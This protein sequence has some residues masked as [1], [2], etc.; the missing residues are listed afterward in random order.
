MTL[1]NQKEN[2]ELEELANRLEADTPA[3]NTETPHP[4][5][6]S[7]KDKAP[8]LC[9]V[10]NKYDKIDNNQQVKVATKT[11]NIPDELKNGFFVI[12]QLEDGKK[13]V[14][15][16]P[17][18]N[19][20][21]S[22]KRLTG[23]KDNMEQWGTFDQVVNAFN[24]G[25]PTY[26]NRGYDGIGF[27]FTK[28]DTYWGID[29]DNCI[30]PKGQMDAWAKDIIDRVDS[31]YE[32]SPSGKGVKIWVKADFAKWIDRIQVKFRLINGEKF[33]LEIDDKKNIITPEDD[34]KGID[35]YFYDYYF[36][37]TGNGDKNKIINKSSID[38]AKYYKRLENTL[39]LKKKNY[40]YDR[41]SVGTNSNKVDIEAYLSHYNVLIKSK[42]RKDSR[43]YYYLTNGCLFNPK[44]DKKDAAIIQDVDGKLGYKCFHTSCADNGW[45]EAKQKI[46]GSDSIAPFMKDERGE[47]WKHSPEYSKEIYAGEIEDLPDN[48]QLEDKENIVFP[49]DCYYGLAKEFAEY[50][51]KY[52]PDIAKNVFYMTFLT[53]IGNILSPKLKLDYNIDIQTRL[54]LLNVGKSS[55]ARKSTGVNLTKGFFNKYFINANNNNF[56]MSSPGSAAGL[57]RVLSEKGTYIAHFDEFSSFTTKSKRIGEELLEDMA[58]L[59][60]NNETSNELKIERDSINIKNAY[61]SMV[62]N[63]TLDKLE[64]VWNNLMENIGLKG[65]IFF[66]LV[67]DCYNE[68]RERKPDETDKVEEILGNYFSWFGEAVREIRFNADAY[69][70]YIDFEKS[71]ALSQASDEEK[72]SQNRCESLALK[73]AMLLTAL[74]KKDNITKEIMDIAIKMASWQSQV[75]L[76]IV[77][78]KEEDK[79][80][81]AEEEIKKRLK[82]DKWLY[83][84]KVISSITRSKKNNKI[85]T[86]YYNNAF[87][88]LERAGLIERGKGIKEAPL[89]RLAG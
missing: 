44:H 28:E 32:I 2:R 23:D 27:I 25:K 18:T 29:L 57:R 38:E 48:H 74:D 11:E 42:E 61:L 62:S 67:D 68:I 6:T 65:R 46:S 15:Y 9:L 85:N 26:S 1:T 81:V 52:H 16:S 76:A 7:T 82:R 17:K 5:L 30:D 86:Q 8:H 84:T 56:Y 13:K 43:T 49:E 66:N 53:I 59:Y 87:S 33:P 45:N 79:L 35:V 14:P 36:T 39:T 40:N 58:S 31:Y 10:P 12:W 50:Q 24:N 89:Y 19:L 71:I 73:L 20:K 54:Y 21:V 3:I 69:Q 72:A 78:P 47:P 60:D 75:R 37:L 80:L 70:A 4:A 41:Q 64:E 34:R 63:I 77:K 88:S 22:C 83:K 51:H 55:I